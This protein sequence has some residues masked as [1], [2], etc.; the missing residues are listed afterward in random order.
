MS[1]YEVLHRL[2]DYR[3][4]WEM[5][6]KRQDVDDIIAEIVGCQKRFAKYYDKFSGLFLRDSVADIAGE[7]YD[8]CV[9]NIDY[10]EETVKVQS[11]AIPTGIILRG[12]G[13][14][15]HYALFIGG[16]LGSLNRL[17]RAG[18]NWCYYFAAYKPGEKEPYHVFVSV[19]DP[20]SG[21]ELWIDPTPGASEKE[22]TLLIPK[23]VN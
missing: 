21:D 3:D 6:V 22:P 15:K 5:V 2:P 13:D 18:I 9:H 7:L 12:M 4:Q 20:V 8:F 16:V 14:C 10:R 11:S 19:Y 17:Y 1:K 23:K